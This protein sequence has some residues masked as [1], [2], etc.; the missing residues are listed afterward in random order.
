MA[1]ARQT[2]DML[3]AE[4]QI[5]LG[6]MRRDFDRIEILAAALTAFNG[7]VPDYEPTFRHLRRGALSEHDIDAMSPRN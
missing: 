1:M 6:R 5:L 3:I 2:T 4:L 7:P